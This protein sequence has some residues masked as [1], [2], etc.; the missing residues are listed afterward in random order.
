MEEGA[1]EVLEVPF[2]H[3][4]GISVTLAPRASA[5]LRCQAPSSDRI[6]V[7]ANVRTLVWAVR[8]R[9]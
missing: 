3:S 9:S 5:L 2:N 4:E 1:E 7:V 6:D 8:Y